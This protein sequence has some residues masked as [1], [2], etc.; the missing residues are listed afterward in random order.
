MAAA[1]VLAQDFAQRV[2]ERRADQ[3]DAGL[4][5]AADRPFVPW[6]RFAKGLRDDYD[7]VNAGLTLGWS[8]GPVEGHLNRLKM[9]TRQMCGRASL[10]L[11]QR[12]GLLAA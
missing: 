1:I 11:L 2:R 12:R 8:H 5:R 6:P 9:L 7:A 4:A 10:D 3:R